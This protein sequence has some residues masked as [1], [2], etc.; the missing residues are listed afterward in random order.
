MAQRVHIILTDDI[1]GSDAAET[2][3]FAIDGVNYEIDLSAD[4][5]ARLRESLSAFVANGR[6]QTGAKAAASSRKRASKSTGEATR[7]REWAKGQGMAVSDRGRVSSE[8]RAA[9]EAAHS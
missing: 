2:V 8:V 7:I 3:S 1:D 9:Y 5:A 4:N 6:K